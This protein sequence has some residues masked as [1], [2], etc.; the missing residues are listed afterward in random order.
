MDP[1]SGKIFGLNEIGMTEEEARQR[2]LVLIPKPEEKK[3]RAMNRH[4][5]RRWA[6]QQRKAKSCS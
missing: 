6:A 4:E 5:R 3:V 2:G 1:N